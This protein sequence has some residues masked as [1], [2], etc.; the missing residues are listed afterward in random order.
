M[1]TSRINVEPSM[2]YQRQVLNLTVEGKTKRTIFELRYLY[3]TDKWY[4]SLFD[5][6]SGNP[7]CLYVP[8][9]ASDKL[10]DNLLEPFAHKRIG[11]MACIPLGDGPSTG[12]PTRYNWDEFGLVWGDSF[13]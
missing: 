4:I 5:A 7:Y 11:W 6:Q 10:L 3:K 13:D 1:N 9:I 8:V 12:N 2:L